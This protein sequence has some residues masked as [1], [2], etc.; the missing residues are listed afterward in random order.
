MEE[1]NDLMQQCKS[2]GTRHQTLCRTRDIYRRIR[3]HCLG[4]ATAPYHIC[5]SHN[6]YS[7]Y[8]ADITIWMAAQD[9]GANGQDV[10]SEFQAALLTLE[11]TF[12]ELGLT[13]APGKS[14]LL[15][16]SGRDSTLPQSRQ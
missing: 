9:Y 5:A 6:H 1:G 3:Q 8:T 10:A 13:L 12:P 7:I 15:R 11:G 16:V 14:Q 2:N 4:I